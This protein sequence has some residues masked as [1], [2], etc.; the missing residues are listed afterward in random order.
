VITQA[1]HFHRTLLEVLAGGPG[2]GCT[3]PNCGR[4]RGVRQQFQTTQ[5][6]TYT[7]F[8]PSRKGIPR[9]K[10]DYK[11][12]VSNFKG[13]FAKTHENVP[14]KEGKKNGVSGVY[15]AA[16]KE[17]DVHAG[18]GVTVFV[19]RDFKNNRVVVMEMPHDDMNKLAVARSFKFKNFGQASGFLN[20][21][22]AIRQK[23][24]SAGGE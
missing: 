16:Y 5:G 9:G 17:G 8:R 13:Q 20:K 6:H 18:H 24:P 15:D 10:A 22:Y 7:L 3:G 19:H 12:R 1:M 21:R 2:S 4:P 23:L 14:M 11:K